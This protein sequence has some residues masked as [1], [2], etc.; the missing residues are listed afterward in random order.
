[1]IKI[2]IHRQSVMPVIPEKLTSRQEVRNA[3]SSQF[4][5]QPIQSTKS[6]DGLAR[7]LPGEPTPLCQTACSGLSRHQQLIVYQSLG[8]PFFPSYTNDNGGL[9]CFLMVNHM[10]LTFY[11][12]ITAHM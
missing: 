5:E 1:M 3:I 8:L 9:V 4:W 11:V 7:H 2:H 10:Q 12:H 6:I